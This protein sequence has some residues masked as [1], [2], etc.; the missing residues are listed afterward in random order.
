MII[1]DA[2]K[3]VLLMLLFAAGF[4]SSTAAQE[5]LK[6]DELLD[7]TSQYLNT[8]PKKAA[9]SLA[10]LKL[11]ES[12]FT[13]DQEGRYYFYNALFLSFSGKHKES[14]TSIESVIGKILEPKSRI[15]LL[16]QL[17]NEYT[18]IGDYENALVAMNQSVLL[19]PKI[20]DLGS[21]ITT[22][23]ASI[24]LLNSLHAYDE[25]MVYANRMYSLEGDGE[26]TLSKCY[27]LANRIETGF[28]SGERQQTQSL[29]AETVRICDAN[30]RQ[31]ISVMAKI[32]AAVD[33]IDTGSSDLGIDAGLSLLLEFVKISD[34]PDYVIQ[35]EEAIARAYL[36]NGELKQAEHYGWLAYQHAQASK[37]LKML[38]KT[39]ETMAKIKR[40][41]GDMASALDYY[42]INLAL[43]KKVLDDQLH[44]NLAYQRVKFDTQDKANQLT[45]L[46]Q[47][48]Q[49]PQHRETAGAKN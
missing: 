1:L 47:K 43:K 26:S 49:D 48:K 3:N 45:L 35:L 46:E 16:Y 11:S 34:P 21:K 38:E 8:T 29:I 23:Q 4:S 42:D 36:N 32:L 40:A 25:A 10:Q 13:K 30:H 31:V 44:K 19:L 14:V 5:K 7:L 33:L 6:V 18:I 12:I 9:A 39:S 24:N 28:L 37:V 2:V 41:Q 15:R 20:V 17:S 22:L 27:G